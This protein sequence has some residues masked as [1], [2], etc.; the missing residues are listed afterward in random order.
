MVMPTRAHRSGHGA[1]PSRGTEANR[2]DQTTR[3]AETAQAT[4]RTGWAKLF[5]L[6]IGVAYAVIIVVSAVGM[7]DTN[8]LGHQDLI[9]GFG[10]SWIL[11]VV[12]AGTAAWGLLAS[13]RR[14]ATKLFGVTIFVAYLGLTAYSVP[15][16][17]AQAYY[18]NVEWGNAIM[19]A[20]TSAAALPIAIGAS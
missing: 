9:G 13:M 15:A 14:S 11:F 8:N 2:R 12:H 6:L 10:M 17:F 18:L 7:P 3:N 5:A 20:L 19:Y 16:A 1:Q 4:R